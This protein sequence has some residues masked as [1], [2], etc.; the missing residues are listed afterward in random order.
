MLA[1]ARAYSLFNMV[2]D[3]RSSTM[4]FYILALHTFQLLASSP[5]GLCDR[6]G[7]NPGFGLH[8]KVRL[9]Q[10]GSTSPENPFPYGIYTSPPLLSGAV[11]PPTPG[12]SPNPYGIFTP[13]PPTPSGAMPPPLQST[14]APPPSPPTPS[15]AMPPPLLSI[16]P[17]P[18]SPPTPSG[19]V[20]PPLLSISP[21]PPSPNA[22]SPQHNA[23]KQPPPN[24]HSSPP[25]PA[26]NKKPENAVWCVAKPTVP[27]DLIQQALDYACGSGAGCD[28]IQPNGA[29]YQPATLLSHASYAFNSYWQKKKQGGGTCDFGGTAM[30]V[31][32]DPSYDQCRFTCN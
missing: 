2:M 14:S 23:P 9:L 1:A 10:V 22:Q 26:P 17:P 3:S 5:F 11:P 8:R 31:T 16:S 12:N 7:I 19:A 20:P 21:P 28:A 15:G 32:V 4:K 25:P 29:C 6:A 27:A 18:P 24:S 30:L 13:S